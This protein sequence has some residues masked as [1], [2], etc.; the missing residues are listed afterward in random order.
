MKTILFVPVIFLA[1]SVGAGEAPSLSV[2]VTADKTAYRHPAADKPAVAAVAL[3]VKNES[4]SAV[5]LTFP[6]GQRYDFVLYDKS[7]QAVARWSAERMFTMAFGRMQLA[8][9]ETR[10]FGDSLALAADGKN[11]LAGDYELEGVLSSSPPNTSKRIKLKI[12]P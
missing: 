4:T 11:L 1:A 7:G 8:A 5:V 2:A 12:G 3:E 6:T 10:K 9:G